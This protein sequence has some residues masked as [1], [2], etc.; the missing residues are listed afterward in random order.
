MTSDGYCTLGEFSSLVNRHPDVIRSWVKTGKVTLPTDRKKYRGRDVYKASDLS[1]EYERHVAK[2]KEQDSAREARRNAYRPSNYIPKETAHRG[3][4]DSYVIKKIELPKVMTESDMEGY[5]KL[6][7]RLIADALMDLGS[8]CKSDKRNRTEAG[9]QLTVSNA[10]RWLLGESD[11]E[12]L[13]LA[14]SLAK[15]SETYIKEKISTAKSFPSRSALKKWMGEWKREM[16]EKSNSD[17]VIFKSGAIPY[18]GYDMGFIPDF[19]TVKPTYPT[20]IMARQ[21]NRQPAFGP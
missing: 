6:G 15:F 11:Q 13:S 2:V 21:H 12:M 3:E 19:P 1:A 5:R 9:E 18:K 20:K 14:C 10:K 16:R 8:P 17:L 7:R 4:F